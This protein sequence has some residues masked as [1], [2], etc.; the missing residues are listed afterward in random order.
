MI[1]VSTNIL[2]FI[3]DNYM[4]DVLIFEPRRITTIVYIDMTSFKY[5]FNSMVIHKGISIDKVDFRVR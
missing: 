2:Y 1:Y 4:Y 3:L 5:H